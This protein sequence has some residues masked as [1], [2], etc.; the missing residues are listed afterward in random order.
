VGIFEGGLG[1]NAFL[2]STR[3]REMAGRTSAIKKYVM[4]LDRLAVTI[5][6]TDAERAQLNAGC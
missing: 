2:L 3:A 1:P 6:V 5:T 4:A